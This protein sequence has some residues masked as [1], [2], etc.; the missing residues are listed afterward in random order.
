MG[1]NNDATEQG[2]PQGQQG[3]QVKISPE[4]RKRQSGYP[5]PENPQQG[6]ADAQ[7]GGDLKGNATVAETP[8]GNK[9]ERT[10]KAMRPRND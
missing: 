1:Q 8:G 2:D 3:G 10:G 7:T 4:E 5:N 9:S 6:D